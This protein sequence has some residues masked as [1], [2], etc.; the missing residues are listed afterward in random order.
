M[1]KLQEQ[2]RQFCREWQGLERIYEDYAKSVNIPYTTLY[3]LDQITQMPDCTQKDICEKTLLPRQ[4]VNS[5]ITG[6]YKQ[7]LIEL[8]EVPED[9]RVKSLSL[10]EKGQEYIAGI[11]PRIQKAEYEAMEEL[12]EEQ[13]ESLLNGMKLYCEQFRKKL[14]SN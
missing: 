13:R 2:T 10:T 8:R 12:S 4:T 6:L 5:V 14:F 1:D 11:L 9:R 7:D 3:I